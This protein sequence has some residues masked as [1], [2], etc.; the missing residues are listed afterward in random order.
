MSY[1]FCRIFLSNQQYGNHQDW[2][3]SQNL[4]SGQS[5]HYFDRSWC[6]IWLT[7]RFIQSQD[8]VSWCSLSLHLSSHYFVNNV[9]F[10][11]FLTFII[12]PPHYTWI[13]VCLGPLTIQGYPY[14]RL[15]KV[16]T[17]M[18]DYLKYFHCD[19]LKLALCYSRLIATA[20]ISYP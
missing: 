18:S 16:L 8:K 13:F 5:Y 9:S 20:S 2:S 11:I 14:H 3:Q 12:S 15:G 19:A 7:N 4:R 10:K 1:F 17:K 6:L